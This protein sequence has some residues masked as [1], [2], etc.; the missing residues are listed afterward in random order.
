MKDT[1][2]GRIAPY[3]PPHKTRK[4]RNVS[5]VVRYFLCFYKPNY[6]YGLETYLSYESDVAHYQVYNPQQFN[7]D[8]DN[9]IATIIASH[10]YWHTEIVGSF[11]VVKLGK[12]EDTRKEILLSSS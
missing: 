10:R 6:A 8:L 1:L 5:F 12:F 7:F 3:V 4:W 11:Y 9:L 2:Y